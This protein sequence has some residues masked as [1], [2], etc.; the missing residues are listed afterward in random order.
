MFSYEHWKQAGTREEQTEFGTPQVRQVMLRVAELLGKKKHHHLDS[1]C[2][3]SGMETT[4]THHQE[5]S[6]ECG[7]LSCHPAQHSTSCG[8]PLREIT[9]VFPVMVKE[10]NIFSL[11]S[12]ISFDIFQFFFQNKTQK[13]C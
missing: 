4:G 5:L 10:I 8:Q 12:N 1:G 11:F 6:S 2:T 3:V 13:I 9:G 7:Q